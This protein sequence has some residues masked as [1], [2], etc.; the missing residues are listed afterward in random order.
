MQTWI[1]LLDCNNFFVSCERLFRPDLEH[2]PV[3][4]LSSNDGCIIARSQEIKDMG[5]PMGVPYFQVK[6]SLQKSGTTIFSS[7]FTLYRDISNRIF[8]LLKAEVD[9]F[10]QYS[11][12]EA[13]FVY[14][15]SD[16]QA[17]VTYLKRHIGQAIGIPVSV[18]LSFTKTQAKYANGVTKRHSG[19]W[20]MDQAV[21]DALAPQISIGEVWGVGKGRVKRFKDVG[22]HT[23]QDLQMM[24]YGWVS[25]QF[26]VEG[27]RL[28]SELTGQSVLPVQT[29]QAKQKSVMS[30]RAFG[31]STNDLLVLEDALAYHVRHTVADIRAQEQEAR[32]ISVYLRPSR[33]STFALR[34]GSLSASLTSPSQDT[35]IILKIANRL[36]RDLYRSGVPYQKIGVLLRDL[37]PVTVTQATLFSADNTNKQ[38]VWSAVD[39]LNKRFGDDTVRVGS[40]LKENLWKGRSGKLSPVYTTRWSDVPIV[41]AT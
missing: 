26:G 18:G 22:I 33:Y 9:V 8:S 7:N 10:E 15:G 20:S 11:I 29:K 21:F 27:V 17:Y 34:G 35:S 13:F 30:S 1:G 3:V 24:R 38:A 32:T 16:P 39:I 31:I 14:R 19:A 6:D 5:I 28:Y 23:V 4:V 12:D 41:K 40:A 2:A 37:S 36:L 25:S